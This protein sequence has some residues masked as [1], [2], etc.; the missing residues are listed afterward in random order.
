MARLSKA[1]NERLKS[2]AKDIYTLQ[3]TITQK[4]LADKVGVGEKTIGNWLKEGNWSKLRR[5]LLTTKQNQI[6][7]LY[8]QLE[9]INYNIKTRPVLRDIPVSHLKPIKT[10]DKQGNVTVEMPTIDESKYPIKEDNTPNSKE[11]DIISKITQS[12]KR[13]ETEIS[14]GEI[15]EVGISFIAFI[16]TEDNDFA[17]K[18]SQYYDAF[19]Q[20]KAK[21]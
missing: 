11:A 17:K 10:T 8:D 4:E 21:N 18:F 5:S 2:L 1:E 14:I 12:I 6:N 19:I 7:Q 15:I 20:T 16:K 13:L 9:S 3:P